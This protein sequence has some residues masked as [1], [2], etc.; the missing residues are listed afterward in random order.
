MMTKQ[1][2]WDLGADTE[3]WWR[4]HIKPVMPHLRHIPRCRGYDFKGEFEGSTVYIDT[5]FLRSEY[6]M[7]GWI[8]VM[9]WG[10]LTGIIGTAKEHFSDNNTS[11]YIG[12]MTE[13]KHYL[14]D[15]KELLREWNAGR[16]E[17]HV[18][19]STDDSGTTTAN[20]YFVIDGWADPK[21]CVIEGPMKEE[22]W[23]PRTEIGKRIDIKD[24]MNGTWTLS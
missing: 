21:Y 2:Y 16:L 23:K 3:R 19:T 4:E 5:K 6:R 12:V 10:K 9:T 14:I 15:A 1:D 18:G 8:E 11:V 13:G 17:L 20:K 24:W 22:L 7:K